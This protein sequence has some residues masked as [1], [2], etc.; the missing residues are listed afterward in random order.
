MNDDANRP[1]AYALLSEDELAHV[2]PSL[3][4]VFP[5]PA[6]MEFDGLLAQLDQAARSHRPD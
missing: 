1:V 3:R 5:L 6:Y 4:K 2:G